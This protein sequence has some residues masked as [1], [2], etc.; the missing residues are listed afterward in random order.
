MLWRHMGAPS[1]SY[2]HFLTIATF[3]QVVRT[4]VINL[5][6]CIMAL[7]GGATHSKNLSMVRRPEICVFL[8]A[9]GGAGD[10]H[11]AGGLGRGATGWGLLLPHPAQS[12]AFLQVVPATVM[13]LVDRVVALQGGGLAPPQGRLP[14]ADLKAHA[15]LDKRAELAVLTHRIAALAQGILAMER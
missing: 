12:V 6:E 5:V 13:E 4:T 11:G 1:L 2:Q 14:A 8:V 9:A 10:C 15:Q 3:L 7:Q